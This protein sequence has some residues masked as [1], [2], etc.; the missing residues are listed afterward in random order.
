MMKGG[1]R[2]LG[3]GWGRWE[4]GE[5]ERRRRKIKDMYSL[6]IVYCVMKIFFIFFFFF[7]MNEER[8]LDCG[9]GSCTVW[10]FFVFHFLIFF[11]L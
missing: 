11:R 5:D 1:V 6:T 2:T 4:M 9:E 8:G 10:N 3:E 7:E